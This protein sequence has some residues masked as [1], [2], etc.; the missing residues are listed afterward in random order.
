MFTAAFCNSKTSETSQMPEGRQMHRDWSTGPT[1]S[2]S[3]VNTNEL[4]PGVY[5]DSLAKECVEQP[6]ASCRRVHMVQFH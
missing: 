5:D 2:C 3:A 4:Q 1:Q 6:K